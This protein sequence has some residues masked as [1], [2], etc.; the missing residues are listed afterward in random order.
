[1]KSIANL[2]LEELSSLATTSKSIGKTQSLLG[3]S[4][5]VVH[6]LIHSHLQSCQR[7]IQLQPTTSSS[8]RPKSTILHSSNLA[9]ML[10]LLPFT[11]IGWNNFE[12]HKMSWKSF[13]HQIETTLTIKSS[14]NKHLPMPCK[15]KQK[16]N[17]GN[18]DCVTSLLQSQPMLTNVAM[19]SRSSKA[20]HCALSWIS[21]LLV[22]KLSSRKFH[23]VSIPLRPVSHVKD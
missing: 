11:P 21:A 4:S 22:F 12:P 23:Q 15:P 10:Q 9:M 19:R 16:G 6:V 14:A 20:N 18:K 7:I 5:L 13:H 2:T 8:T 17:C 1:M 3:S